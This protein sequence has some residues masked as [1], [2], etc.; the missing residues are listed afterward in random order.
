[1]ISKQVGQW[2]FRGVLAQCTA[3]T[4]LDLRDS[5]D[6]ED[7]LRGSLLASWRWNAIIY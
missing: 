5:Y 4:L 1:M 3:L 7:V 6:R 2:A